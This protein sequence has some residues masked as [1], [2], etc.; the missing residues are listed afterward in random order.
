MESE[1][2]T[3]FDTIGTNVSPKTVVNG[4]PCFGNLDY[5]SSEVNLTANFSLSNS[6]ATI[7][8]KKAIINYSDDFIRKCVTDSK[9]TLFFPILKIDEGD[10]ILDAGA[11]WGNIAA[12]IARGFPNT[13]VYAFDKTVEQ[14]FFADQIR[15]Q[16]NL[17]NMHILQ[18]EIVNTPFEK[19]FFDVVILLGVLDSLCDSRQTVSPRNT[20]IQTLKHIRDILQP[21]G[22]L[23]IGVENRIGYR[24]FRRG[25]DEHSDP[26]KNDSHR[27][28]TYSIRGYTRLLKEAGFNDLSFYAAIP[29]YRFPTLICDLDSVKT[30]LG[31]GFANL[32]PR[33]ILAN[34]VNS[35]YI[36]ARR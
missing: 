7:G 19:N 26:R 21:R 23:L 1:N 14:L 18:G 27:R 6:A 16:E 31:P 30:L 8:W 34:L 29:D 15:K 25:R 5:L 2:W 10:R 13:Q 3:I 36:M 20:Q 33:R 28:Y 22:R 12:Q 35:F 4:I 24:H 9:R 11:G 17:Q 32:L